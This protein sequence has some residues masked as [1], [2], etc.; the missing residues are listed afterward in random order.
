MPYK[1][2][3][4]LAADIRY[5]LKEVI[6][7]REVPSTKFMRTAD[8]IAPPVSA[9]QNS[10]NIPELISGDGDRDIDGE[11]AAN[12]SYTLLV[13]RMGNDT[14]RTKV[15]GWETAID[16]VNDVEIKE[17]IDLEAVNAGILYDTMFL[18]KEKR[19]AD[20]VS[21][22]DSYG[23]SNKAT[24]D[25]TADNWL[26]GTK[27]WDYVDGT[28]APRLFTTHKVEKWDIS[29]MIPAT[30]IPKV[31]RI[32]DVRG[33]MKYQTDP[34]KMSIDE[35]ALILKGYLGIKEVIPVSGGYNSTYFHATA[36]NF[37]RLWNQSNAIFGILSSGGPWDKSFARQPVF[38]KPTLGQQYIF[39]SYDLPTNDQ[40]ITRI[41]HVIGEKIDYT[42]GYMF[43]GIDAIG[44]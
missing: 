18:G 10:G 14:F 40:V 16:N 20:A 33:V 37:S 44:T 8:K 27:M 3:V 17:L 12:G 9:T 30:F 5:D 24:N 41:K 28:I 25:L 6:D 1:G 29:A 11:R 31:I 34:N 32:D 15:R 23:S 13:W 21:L 22:Y 26:Q 7:G 36:P 42:M 35:Q 2:A 38:T 39:E 4:G 19:V 43:K